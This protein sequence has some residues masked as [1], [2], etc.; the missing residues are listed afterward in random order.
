MPVLV[1]VLIAPLAP[2]LP[3]RASPLLLALQHPVDWVPRLT[4]LR[5]REGGERAED[6][7]RR[8]QTNHGAAGAG[9]PKSLG[10]TVE[11]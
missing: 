1:L 11:A 3:R 10:E 2:R 9:D 7:S 8:Q 5:S 6:R 4:R